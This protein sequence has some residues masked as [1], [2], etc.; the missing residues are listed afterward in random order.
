MP[1]VMVIALVIV[2]IFF[3]L[4]LFAMVWRAIER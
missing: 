1:I 3:M 2:L 4:P